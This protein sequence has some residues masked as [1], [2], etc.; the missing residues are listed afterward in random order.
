MQRMANWLSTQG[1]CVSSS[2]PPTNRTL[3]RVWTYAN[4]NWSGTPSVHHNWTIS[5]S[6]SHAAIIF[7]DMSYLN[8][9][10]DIWDVAT[11]FHQL[12]PDVFT[13]VDTTDPSNLSLI[14]FKMLMYPNS[15][16]KIMS[17]ILFWGHAFPAIRA[18]MHGYW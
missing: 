10:E 4:N 6:L 13:P 8:I 2:G 16:S 7:N 18:I 15:E 14:S 17:N 3:G 11:K 5:E 9:A 1:M 12:N